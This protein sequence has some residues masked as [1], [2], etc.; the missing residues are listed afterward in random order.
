[1]KKIHHPAGVIVPRV[2]PN[3]PSLQPPFPG[4][5]L[6]ATPGRP[7][8]DRQLQAEFRDSAKHAAVGIPQGVVEQ[9]LDMIRGLEDAA[10]AMQMFRLFSRFQ[11]YEGPA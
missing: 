6:R 8:S 10:D 2:P 1:M 7:L 3:Y 4:G 5:I 9:S 11:R